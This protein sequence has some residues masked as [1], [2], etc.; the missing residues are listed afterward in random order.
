LL[1]SENSSPFASLAI[2]DFRLIV[3]ARL[4]MILAVQMQMTTIGLQVYYEYTV[5]QPE[6]IRYYVL[7]LVGLYEAIPFILN[8]FYS[9]H[10]ADTRSRK[11]IIL[12]SL[13]ILFVGSL[14]LT[15][16]SAGKFSLLSSFG[17]YPLLFTVSVFGIV[18]SFIGA[19]TNPFISTIV[20]RSLYVNATTWNTTVFHFAS[21]LGPM[22]AGLIYGLGDSSTAEVIYGINS[23]FFL[24]AFIFLIFVRAHGNPEKKE[25][26]PI[27][28]SISAG[29]KFVFGNRLLLSALTLDLFAVLFGGAVAMIPAFTDKVLHEGPQIA[30][31][32]RTAPAVGAILMA[33]ILA[34]R[35]PGSNSG[36]LLLIS[37]L[38]FGLFTIGFALSTTFWVAFLFLLL[39]GLADNFSVVIRHTIV[40]LQTP[41]SMRGRVS[42]V[43]GIFIGSSNE[44]GSYESGLAARLIGLV[45][46]IIFGGIMVLG[47]VVGINFSF[48]ELKKTNLTQSED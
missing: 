7:G 32:L 31:F 33:V 28:K 18:R 22:V 37:V 36:K 42:S 2:R 48:P 27:L 17:Y 23:V 12:Y 30:G 3:F 45:P 25:D 1:S 20:P 11:K 41:E 13:F 10:I 38:A 14:F 29:V 4:F 40:Q 5:H 35:P 26:E 6:K 16:F 43:N 21:V 46:S 15:F 47:V 44:I 9:G 24:I 39:T 34:L 8:S 19:A